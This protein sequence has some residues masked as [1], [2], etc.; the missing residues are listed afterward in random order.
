MSSAD[1]VIRYTRGRLTILNGDGLEAAA[2][3][4]YEAGKQTYA[5]ILS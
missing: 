5:R 1:L 4:C 2:C 3:G